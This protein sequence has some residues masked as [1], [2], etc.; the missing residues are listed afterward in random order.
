MDDEKQFF[1]MRHKFLGQ[2]TPRQSQVESSAATADIEKDQADDQLN[3]STTKSEK[4]PTNYG[5][6]YL[7]IINMKNVFNHVNE[8]CIECMKTSLK[9]H[10]PCMQS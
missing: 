8:I 2:P 7:F 10:Q 4:K 9:T 1:L 6:N 5:K 3:Q